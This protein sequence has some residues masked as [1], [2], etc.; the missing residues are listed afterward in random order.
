MQMKF[1]QN[2]CSIRNSSADESEYFLN[3]P[4]NEL[5]ENDKLIC[6]GQLTEIECV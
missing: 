4:G 3:I 5:S 6:E 1:Y 2:L